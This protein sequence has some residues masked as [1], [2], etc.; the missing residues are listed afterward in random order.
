M[1][2]Y[3]ERGSACGFCYFKAVKKKVIIFCLEFD[4]LKFK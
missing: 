4:I 2:N 3:E 1:I